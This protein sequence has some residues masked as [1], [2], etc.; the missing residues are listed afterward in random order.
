MVLEYAGSVYI[1][2]LGFNKSWANEL[3][4]FALVIE[5]FIVKIKD[6]RFITRKVK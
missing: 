2:G 5:F 6:G 4:L 3:K 1:A